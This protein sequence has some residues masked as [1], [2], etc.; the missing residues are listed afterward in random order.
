MLEK[1]FRIFQRKKLNKEF[2]VELDSAN[3]EKSL[4]NAN[5]EQQLKE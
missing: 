4:K 2:G 3:D 5:R 1:D